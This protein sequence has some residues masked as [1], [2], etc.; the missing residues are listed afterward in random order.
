MRLPGAFGPVLVLAAHYAWVVLADTAFEEASVEASQKQA[1]K[2][3]HV[4]AGNWQLARGKLK[5][6]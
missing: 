6:A 4:R 2:L 1:E 3:A 5:R